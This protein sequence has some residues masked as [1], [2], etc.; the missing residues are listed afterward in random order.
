MKFSAPESVR[1]TTHPRGREALDRPAP[2]LKPPLPLVE[3]GGKVSGMAW[4]HCKG[5]MADG[6]MTT[7]LLGIWESA[8]RTIFGA[9]DNVWTG[10]R[11]AGGTGGGGL[12][13]S[14]SSPEEKPPNIST[15]IA[16]YLHCICTA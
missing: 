1:K 9:R 11:E 10:G 13:P 6:R 4:S 2:A 15:V 7:E 16:L 5:R 12:D 8:G 3:S 14:S